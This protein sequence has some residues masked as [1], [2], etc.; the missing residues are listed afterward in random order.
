MTEYTTV[1]KSLVIQ[2][3]VEQLTINELQRIM[4]QAIAGITEEVS[5][6]LKTLVAS[7][8]TSKEDDENEEG[9]PSPDEKSAFEIDLDTLDETEEEPFYSEETLELTI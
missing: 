9:N 4:T 1:T 2:K 7:V 5:E 8:E 6:A 3:D